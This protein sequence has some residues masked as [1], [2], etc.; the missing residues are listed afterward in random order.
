M[1]TFDGTQAFCEDIGVSPE[2]VV[3]LSLAYELKSVTLGEWPRKGWID[4]CK[5]LG[6]VPRAPDRAARG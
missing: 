6:C 4:G 1:I 2:D 5:A 3:L